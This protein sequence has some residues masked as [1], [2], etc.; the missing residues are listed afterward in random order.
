[1]AAGG[2]LREH[3]A[4]GAWAIV[5]LLAAATGIGFVLAQ[6]TLF[7]PGGWFALDGLRVLDAATTWQHGGNPYA[8]PGYLYAPAA[9]LLAVPLAALGGS[10]AIVVWLALEVALVAI[11]TRWATSRCPWWAT[12]A[13]IP[14]VL[15][16]QPVIAD[17]LLVNVTVALTFGMVLVVRN[18]RPV[19]GLLL[20]VLAAAFPK[21]LLAPFVL[22]SLVRRRQA[23]GGIVA[24]AL[25]TTLAA[26]L[27]AGP[28]AY[29]AFA[30]LLASGGGVGPAFVGN[31]SLTLVSVPLAIAVGL[32][33]G[34]GFLLV[35]LRRDQVT[36]L[37]WAT[38]AGIFLGPYAGGYAG[39]P[40]LA[41]LPPFWA[42]API[43]ALFAAMTMVVG[44][45]LYPVSGAVVLAVA[46]LIRGRDSPAQAGT[47]RTGWRM[48]S[49]SG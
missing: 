6:Q 36:S 46:L 26:V 30:A 40:F 15:L 7:T 4:V 5:G 12:A 14:C 23:F 10:A 3:W 11:G 22:W 8:I 28:G 43:L 27:I 35:L 21:P 39:L 41:A 45:Q 42:A 1:M 2:W 34:I 47:V 16:F 31:T 18:D 29:G 19:S 17:L 9:T 48:D 33:V 38:V 25:A 32:A 44:G 13:A 20:G 24:G 49:Q 37:L